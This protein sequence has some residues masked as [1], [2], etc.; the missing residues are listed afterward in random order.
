M[1]GQKTRLPKND[2]I[3]G[4]KISLKDFPNVKDLRLAT[5]D[6]IRVQIINPSKRGEKREKRERKRQK[7]EKILL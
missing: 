3:S 6:M 1:I 2:S 5:V 4:Y 7:R